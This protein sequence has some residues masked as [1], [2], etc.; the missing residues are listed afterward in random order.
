MPPT[1]TAPDA[2][3]AYRPSEYH[4]WIDGPDGPDYH[5]VLVTHG[6]RLNAEDLAARRQV[7]L[8]RNPMTSTTMWVFMAMHR[9]ETT[10]ARWDDFRGMVLDMVPVE[11]DPDDD[12]EDAD[13][14]DLSTS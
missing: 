13:P 2:P 1:E 12:P 6:D 11:T 3:P 7:S 14:L 9:T 4:V 10:A 8:K 5:R